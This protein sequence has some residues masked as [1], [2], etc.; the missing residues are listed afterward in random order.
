MSD[1]TELNNGIS[2][3]EQKKMVIDLAVHG[4]TKIYDVFK[5]LGFNDVQSIV[6]GILDY[7]SIVEN[8]DELLKDLEQYQPEIRNRAEGIL[9]M[10]DTVD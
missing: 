10:R 8:I 4:N 9:D 5:K 3:E 7:K 1:K 2:Q 6:D